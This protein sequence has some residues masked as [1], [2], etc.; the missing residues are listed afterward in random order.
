MSDE[1]KDK[2]FVP[3]FTTKDVGQ[4]TGLGLAVVHGIVTSHGGDINVESE[5]GHGS[6]FIITLPRKENTEGEV[7]QDNG[8]TR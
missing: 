2:I 3:F 1:V 4:G 7:T 6:R 8:R 5:V